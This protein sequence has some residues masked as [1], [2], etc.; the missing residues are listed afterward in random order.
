MCVIEIAGTNAVWNK[1]Q[2]PDTCD[3]AAIDFLQ[4]VHCYELYLFL[5]SLLRF[6]FI[7]LPVSSFEDEIFDS[8]S[9]MVLLKM[10]KKQVFA[11]IQMREKSSLKS[12]CPYSS[13]LK[14]VE[15][16]YRPTIE[17]KTLTNCKIRAKKWVKI[18]MENDTQVLNDFATKCVPILVEQTNVCD[19][20]R[21]SETHDSVRKTTKIQFEC[22]NCVWLSCSR[23]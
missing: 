21:L 13:T 8:R 17:T 7:S 20:V 15:S 18:E 6:C 4:I 1:C 11:V 16:E 10:R 19:C 9:H 2:P 14:W 22:K 23:T 12:W 3:K 5:L